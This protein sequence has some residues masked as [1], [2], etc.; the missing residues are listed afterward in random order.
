MK[1]VLVTGDVMVDHH[2]YEGQRLNASATDQPGVRAIRQHGGA[3]GVFSLIKEILAQARSSEKAAEKPVPGSDWSVTFGLTKPSE[4]AIPCGHHSLAVWK[5]FALEGPIEGP[6]DQRKVWQADLLMGYGHDNDDPD[7]GAKACPSHIPEV[8]SPPPGPADVLVLDD[9]GFVFRQR[10]QR[11]C[12]FLPP[13]EAASPRWI[14]LKMSGPVCQGDLWA[15]LRPYSDRLIVIVSA[16]DLRRECVR[17]SKGLSWERTV[18]ELRCALRTTPLLRDLESVP[19]HLLVTFSADGALWLDNTGGQQKATLVFDA[20]G[21]ENGWARQFKGKAF[22][23]LSCLVATIVR[24]IIRDGEKLRLEVAI[25]AGLSA[26]RDLAQFGH[27]EVCKGSPTGFPAKRLAGV[28]L[29]GDS[30]FAVSRVPWA[31]HEWERCASDPE[32]PG[33]KNPWQIVVASQAPFGKDQT[34]SLVGLATQVVLY[35]EQAIKALPHARFGK[36]LTADRLEIE[37]LRTIEG[38]MRC[39]QAEEKPK[40]PLSI[41]VFGP[42]GAGKS[43]GVQQISDGVFGKDAW[44]EFNLSQFK[45]VEDLIGAFHHV[46]DM[47]LSGT[48]PVVFWDEFDSREYQWLQ[49]LLAPMQDGRFQEGQISHF[50]GKCVF[51]FAGATSFAYAEF[52]PPKPDEKGFDAEVWKDYCLK[53][54]PDFSSRL[55]AYYDVLGPNQRTTWPENDRTQKR[56]PDPRDVCTPLRRALLIRAL[57]KEPKD[58]VLDFDAELLQAL[59]ETGEYQHGARS[60]EKIVSGLK[61]LRDGQPIRRS[62]LLPPGQLAMHI[63]DLNA[64][65][66][67]LQRHILYRQPQTIEAVAKAVHETWRQLSQEEGWKMQPNYDMPYD[68]LGEVEQEENRAAARRIP[69]ILALAG[70]KI[71]RS[72]EKHVEGLMEQLTHHLRRL[73]EAEHEGWMAH[74]K[75]NGW[76]YDEKRDD[77]KKQHNALVEYSKLSE[78]DQKKDQNSVLHFPDMLRRAGFRIVWA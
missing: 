13:R 15:E 45:D 43:F 25:S 24:S 19:C 65:L 8:I 5:P 36:L 31:D 9:G 51:I 35:G 22:G 47:V 54:G 28:I 27:G 3:M 60:V 71:E 62:A 34:P 64:F 2:L 33:G 66:A 74:R 39:Y 57:L 67:I 1:T 17:M 30:G 44:L 38:L 12:W 59:L 18:E 37:A 77:I 55:D 58:L 23:Y 50:I 49:Y 70:L 10:G 6:K 21:S 63:K 32:N 75:K 72:D 14:V 42:P 76:R 4:G 48:T 73:A 41:G 16:N 11:Q 29:R 7:D 46:R 56:Q 53:K 69:D 78:K 20:G 61:P 26:M 40:K 52:G 68:D